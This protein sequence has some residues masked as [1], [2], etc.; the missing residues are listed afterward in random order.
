M[1]KD[2]LIALARQTAKKHSLD[3]VLVCAVVERE[4]NWN[5]CAYRYEPEFFKNYVVELYTTNRITITEAYARAF[6][7]G[8]MQIMGQC[9]REDGFTGDW[10]TT[11]CDDPAAGLE[12]GCKHLAHKLDIA[13]G[14]VRQGLLFWNG[15]GDK[16][17]PDRVLALMSRYQVPTNHDAVQDAAAASN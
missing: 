2:E 15:G 3:D 14:N 8:L 11:L 9:A 12:W 4:S 5:P 10:F 17:Y 7:W 1:T 16:L 6:S 13:H